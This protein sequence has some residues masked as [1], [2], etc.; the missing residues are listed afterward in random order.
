MNVLSLATSAS[1]ALVA[2]SA[3]STPKAVA[4]LTPFKPAGCATPSTSGAALTLVVAPSA[5]AFKYLIYKVS[6]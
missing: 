6:R 3:E 1:C 5:S 4:P 2:V